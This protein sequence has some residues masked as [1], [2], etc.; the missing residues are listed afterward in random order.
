MQFVIILAD[1]YMLTQFFVLLSLKDI[2][3]F[4]YISSVHLY[5]GTV[6]VCLVGKVLAVFSWI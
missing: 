5:S 6:M 3:W 2:L 1:L 4:S